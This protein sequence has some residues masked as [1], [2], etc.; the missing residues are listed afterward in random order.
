VIGDLL[1][2]YEA[3][4]VRFSDAVSSKLVVFVLVMYVVKC[5]KCC[6]PRPLCVYHLAS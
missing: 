3:E 4:R 6:K 1:I 2:L 5:C